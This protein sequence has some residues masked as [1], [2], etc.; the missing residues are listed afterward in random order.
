MSI[1]RYDSRHKI[2]VGAGIVIAIALHTL[3]R[4]R[5]KPTY[6]NGQ[7]KQQGSVVMGRNHGTWAWF[8]PNGKRKMQGRFERG[9]RTGLWVT[10]SPT[11]DT[12]T[13]S[14]YERDRLNGEHRVFGSDGR[15]VQVI[16][17]RDDAP[18]SVRPLQE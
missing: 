3:L 1:F 12:L 13:T 7:V 18:L 10:F 4:N 2:I 11:G 15:P 6:D 17:Y 8:H 9:K 16:L 5:E 14:M